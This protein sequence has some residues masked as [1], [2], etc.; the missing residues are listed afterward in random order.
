MVELPAGRVKPGEFVF[1]SVS[2]SGEGEVHFCLA[3]DHIHYSFYV[4]VMTAEGSQMKICQL[5]YPEAVERLGEV[6]ELQRGFVQFQVRGYIKN[7]CA[8][9]QARCAPECKGENMVDAVK[10]CDD[11][12]QADCSVPPDGYEHVRH[13]PEQ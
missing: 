12:R 3:C 5:A 11:R 7:E 2:V 10:Q 6:F 8:E 13:Q 1:E 9:K 4:G